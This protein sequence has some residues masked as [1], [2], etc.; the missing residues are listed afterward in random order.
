MQAGQLVSQ[1]VRGACNAINST[2]QS[3]NTRAT[4]GRSDWEDT[5]R[6]QR[7]HQP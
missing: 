5:R 1:G 4:S 7:H 6:V 3:M 2:I